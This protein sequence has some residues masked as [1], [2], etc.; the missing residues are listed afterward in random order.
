MSDEQG[1][2]RQEKG[3]C[4]AHGYACPTPCEQPVAIYLEWLRRDVCQRDLRDLPF[5]FD[6]NDIVFLFLVS[7]L[8]R[9]LTSVDSMFLLSQDLKGLD[10]FLLTSEKQKMNVHQTENWNLLSLVGSPVFCLTTHVS[11]LK[12]DNE[13]FP[14]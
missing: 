13:K 11:D 2:P 7:N 14:D 3:D 1:C 5:E 4:R 8:L 9:L 12:N 10:V 6:S